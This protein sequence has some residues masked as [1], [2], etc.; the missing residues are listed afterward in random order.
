M[1][2]DGPERGRLVEVTGDPRDDLVQRLMTPAAARES[3]DADDGTSDRDRTSVAHAVELFRA[4]DATRETKRS[5]VVAVARVLENRRSLLKDML[6]S[7]DEDALFQ[8]ANQFDVRHANGRQHDDYA[9]EFLDWIFWWYLATVEL[10]DR[11]LA[12]RTAT[13]APT[14]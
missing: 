4:R 5:A 1:A 7:Q 11:I 13:V 14:T 8:I 6:L 3:T 12:Q 2:G 10:T 9:E